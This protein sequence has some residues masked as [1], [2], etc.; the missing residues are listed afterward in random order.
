MLY[1]DYSNQVIQM[2]LPNFNSEMTLCEIDT[3]F[4]GRMRDM[5]F[6]HHTAL[7]LSFVNKRYPTSDNVEF[8]KANF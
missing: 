8:C 4:Q 6:I 3:C 1:D 2:S 7:P 5:F